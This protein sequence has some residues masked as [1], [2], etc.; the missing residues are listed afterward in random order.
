MGSSQ[1]P[2]SQLRGHLPCHDTINTRIRR[3]IEAEPKDL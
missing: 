1:T 2:S 3:W